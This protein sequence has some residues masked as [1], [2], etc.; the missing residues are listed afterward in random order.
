MNKPIRAGV[1]GGIG[2][3]KSYVC[4]LFHILH[5]I[6]I[7]NTDRKVQDDIMHRPH[8][9]Q[10][11]I[12]NYGEDSYV[13]GNLNKEKFRKLLFYNEDARKTMDQIISVELRN[14]IDLW[15]KTQSTPYVIIECAILF[16]HNMESLFDK[17]ITVF[18]PMEIR[19]Q[20]LGGR[21]KGLNPEKEAAF[22]DTH[23]K[24]IDIQMPDEEKIKRSDY[25]IKSEDDSVI[26]EI[27]ELHQK[28][29]KLI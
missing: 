21:R 27:N 12:D 8:I 4:E 26:S 6:E 5:D 15:C 29:I 24:I 25:V 19:L 7:Y 16:E 2:S 22:S 9:H 1:T 10:Q 17:I 11:V 14:D 23:K 28:L 18:C 13:N 3:G 20:R